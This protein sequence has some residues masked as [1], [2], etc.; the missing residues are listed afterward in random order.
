MLY[1]AK[2]ITKAFSKNI[3][4]K[5]FS[6]KVEKGDMI[7]I[8]G[9]K[10][11]GKTTLM[12]ILGGLIKPNVGEI[13]TAT[14][15]VS[16]SKGLGKLRK[17]RQSHIGYV[18]TEP[19]LL[20]ELTVFENLLLADKK[21]PGTNKSKK[22]KAKETLKRVGIVGRSQYM[23]SELTEV[24]K[25]QVNIAR[26]IINKPVM[27]LLDEPTVT[28]DAEGAYQ[29]MEV[30]KKLN[31]LGVTIVLTTRNKM[32]ASMC[33]KAVALDRSINVAEINA[34][35]KGGIAIPTSDTT[36]ISAV[37]DGAE[38]S[39]NPD[40]ANKVEEDI[41]IPEIDLTNIFDDK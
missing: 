9:K 5:D 26:A 33:K 38:S 31:M 7:A 10:G 6:L 15:V 12:Q 34:K 4:I 21:N 40:S 29:I 25:Q 30:L 32:V 3:I 28:L 23:P 13:R 39:E 20:P 8:V 37:N 17:L 36:T 24:E 16:S 22:A 18:T 11:S 35:I 14:R 41:E 27:L 1:E 19:I 2:H